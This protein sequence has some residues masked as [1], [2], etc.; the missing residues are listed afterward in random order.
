M[1]KVKHFL[2]SRTVWVG[3]IQIAV[4]VTSALF[5]VNLGDAFVEELSNITMEIVG[6]SGGI[7]SIYYRIKALK[8][9]VIVG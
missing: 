2:K 9:L 3:I 8:K 1:T 4:S 5:K 6:M 7:A